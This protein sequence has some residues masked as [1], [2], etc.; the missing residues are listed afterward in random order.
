MKQ[1]TKLSLALAIMILISPAVLS[2]IFFHKKAQ[3]TEPN[4]ANA[5]DNAPTQPSSFSKNEK[6]ESAKQNTDAQIIK[7]N[8]ISQHYPEHYNPPV[9][10]E[11]K[12]Q[13][14]KKETKNNNDISAAEKLINPQILD[15]KDDVKKSGDSRYVENLE[16]A[17]RSGWGATIICNHSNIDAGITYRLA[18][19]PLFKESDLDLVVGLK[20]A[21]VGLSKNFYKNWDLGL[22]GTINYDDG[23]KQLGVYVKYSF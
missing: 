18:E 4:T 11:K 14:A 6:A 3:S 5:Y 1:K 2:P 13:V 9:H 15:V 16:S 20:G 17:E 10:P 22:L 19:I 8:L 23:D 7:P 12:L 21:G